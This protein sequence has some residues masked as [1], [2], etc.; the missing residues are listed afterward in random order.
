MDEAARQV[1][2]DVLYL[3]VMFPV[4]LIIALVGAYYEGKKEGRKQAQNEQARTEL[5]R[6][7]GHT[8]G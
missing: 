6:E 4:L 1:A 5:E 7:R 8:K 3:A 2:V